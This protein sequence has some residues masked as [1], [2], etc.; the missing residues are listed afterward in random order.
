M[1]AAIYNQYG[2]PE[3]VTIAEVDKPIPKED[4]IL[5]KVVASTVNRT[6][7]GFRSANYFIVRFFS[8]LFKPN[9][10]ILG[11][12]YAGVVEQIGT[13]VTSFKVGDKV[14]GYNDE[15]F[16]SHAQYK[17]IKEN[18]AVTIA[19]N[20]LPLEEAV[21]LTEGG[22]YAL[23]DIKAA[24]VKSRDKVLINGATGCIG[25]AAVQLCKYF[26]AEVTAVCPTLN[27]DLVKNLGAD[28][29][30]DYQNEDFTK[31]N[32]EFDFIFDAVGKSSFSLCKPLLKPQGIYIS[33]ELGKNSENPFLAISTSFSKG[34]KLLF[35]L[36][37]IDKEDVEF[38][39]QLA[40]NN[41]FKP[42]IDRSYPLND[43]VE[44]HRYV[45]TGQ[46]VGSVVIVIG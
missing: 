15:K 43:I 25:S 40:E 37:S 9:Q 39:K 2:P 7:C 4:E 31:I 17:T 44:A 36:P 21:A 14:I 30:I 10:P 13:K 38:L 20:N 33:T 5:I 29:I 6:D 18:E 23:C 3:V 32:K 22:H 24:K 8:G 34:K 26:G 19:P 12:E 28:Y 11:C 45:E 35:P 41:Q 42:V 16:G 46:K 1:K 27:I